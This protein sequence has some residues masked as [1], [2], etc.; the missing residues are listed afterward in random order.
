[1][2]LSFFSSS[3]S[4]VRGG[5][6]MSK[7]RAEL[8]R[9]TTAN[10]GR[11][12]LLG[13][14]EDRLPNGGVR[15]DGHVGIERVDHFLELRRLRGVDGQQAVRAQLGDAGLEGSVQVAQFDLFRN[16]RD[17]SAFHLDLLVDGL[18]VSW[19]RA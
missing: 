19:Q 5:G 13:S 2:Q 10:L 7:C 17:G 15:W 11:T 18:L 3:G 4:C 16:V 6:A 12:Q 14:L 9:C 1:M 8:W